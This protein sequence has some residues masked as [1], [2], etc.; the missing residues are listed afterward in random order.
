MFVRV[1][2]WLVR[3]CADHPLAPGSLSLARVAV[4]LCHPHVQLLAVAELVAAK[5]DFLPD[6]AAA[7]VV[8]KHASTV[9]ALAAQI[10]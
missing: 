9:G 8:G 1:D 3:C 6:F 7:A 10:A 5:H 2:C 4:C